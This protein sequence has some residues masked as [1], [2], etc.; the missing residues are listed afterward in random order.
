MYWG[1]FDSFDVDKWEKQYEEIVLA[2]ITSF[3]KNNI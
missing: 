2:T 3:R 1:S